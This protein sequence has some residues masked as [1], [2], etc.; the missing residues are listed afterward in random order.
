MNPLPKPFVARSDGRFNRFEKI[1]L[2]IVTLADR[3]FLPWNLAFKAMAVL[4]N[5]TDTGSTADGEP[6]GVTRAWR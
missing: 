5:G 4:Q 1:L 2:E 6:Y 3:S